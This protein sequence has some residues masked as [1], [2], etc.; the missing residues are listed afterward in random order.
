MRRYTLLSVV[1]FTISILGTALPAQVASEFKGRVTDRSGAAVPAAKVRL[2]EMRSGEHY[3][4]A[5]GR[6][7]Y[8]D[9]ANLPPGQY[10]VEADAAGFGHT[11]RQDVTL[12]VGQTVAVDL[13]LAVG[14]SRQ[15][16][17]V[18]GDVP[19]LQA[20]T[21]DIQA[22]VRQNHIE[23]IP[24]NSRNFINLTQLVPGV[25][26]PP[27]TLLPRINGGRPRTNEYLFDGISALQPEPGQVAF[28]PILDDIDQFTVETNNVSAEFGR[29]NGGVVNVSTRYGTN[30]LH[31]SLFEY[32]RNE[33]LN[34]RNY[35]APA[36][37]A[38][39]A[40]KPEY[41]RNL[42]GGTIGFPILKDRLFF[43]GDYQGIKQLIGTTRIS[44][45]P[46]L[47]ERSGNFN[48]V[49]TI[50]NPAST[51]VVGGRYIRTQFA[52]NQITTPFDPAAVA[53]LARIPLP[54]AAGAANN[55]SRTANDSDHQ[56]QFD[57]RFDAAYGARD[58]AFIRY[59][60]YNEVELPV[61]PFPDGSGVLPAT[62]V[63][64]TGN[65]QGHTNVLGQ[66]AVFNETHTFT[67]RLSN[68]A[69][70]GYTRRAN[71]QDG[72]T[73][74]NTASAAL[75]IPGIPTN[76]AFNNALPLFTFTGFQQLGSS[77]STFSQYQ[78]GVYEFVDTMSYVRGA[79][80]IKFGG[81]IRWY[82]LNAISPPNPTGSFA[83]TT[84]GTDTQNRSLGQL[85]RRQRL[86]KLP[87][88]P[89]GYL[90]HRSPDLGPSPARPCAGVFRAGRL[91]D[92]PTP[93][94]QPGCSLD[95]Q[96][97]FNREEQSGRGV[98]SE[99]AAS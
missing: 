11:V 54:T 50:Y 16:V 86:G 63:L 61:T 2:T 33:D 37:V 69:R 6:D 67:T 15:T 9:F 45:V 94:C 39:Q 25:E 31:G 7:G 55:Y 10:Q 49:S 84:T 70:V 88:R 18:T 53:L 66:Q 71:Y 48:G 89:G 28:F 90:L 24:L 99:H 62:S 83:F 17:T 60:Y 87:A 34:A 42:Y 78:T 68:D 77:A 79:H 41:R 97:S 57:T 3:D 13:A 81:D 40:R 29:F 22:T 5:T 27:G 1:L 75:N 47:A 58:H 26:L 4:S 21:S 74:G 64:G 73:A 65:V 95:L 44:T 96:Q 92:Q 93:Y 52:G 46:T 43:F 32:L 98:Q 76:A 38:G 20:Q 51:T 23:A 85:H 35:F 80:D 12:A 72:V 56:N 19:L 30:Q 82:Q 8:Y 14:E 59:T 36:A 91:A